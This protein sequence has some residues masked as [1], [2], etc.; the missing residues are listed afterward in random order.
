MKFL[1]YDIFSMLSRETSGGKMIPEIDGI[2]FLA[3][4]SVVY[5]HLW[6]NF[7]AYAEKKLLAIP[8]WFHLPAQ[9]LN[10]GGLGVEV[11][12]CPEWIY[13]R[14]SFRQPVSDWRKDR[15]LAKVFQTPDNSF[16]GPLHTKSPIFLLRRIY[17]HERFQCFGHVVSSLG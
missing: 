8:E 4:F 7:A 13:S 11:F 5:F 15:F 16:R 1:R 2:R 10:Q 14:S 9:I 3:I 17:F 12:F 6:G